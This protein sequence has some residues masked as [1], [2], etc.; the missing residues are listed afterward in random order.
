MSIGKL[1]QEQ[2]DFIKDVHKTKGLKLAFSSG[3]D[4]GITNSH[5]LI[6]SLL[7][8]AEENLEQTKKIEEMETELGQSCDVI[9]K[10]QEQFTEEE[11]IKLREEL[12]SEQ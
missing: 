6:I 12:E 2:I 1:N 9:M 10:F 5:E 8:M 7:G 4:G 3:L 11:L